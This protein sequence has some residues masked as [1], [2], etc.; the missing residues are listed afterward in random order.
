[1][2]AGIECVAGPAGEDG[3]ALDETIGKRIDGHCQELGLL[4]RPIVNMCV[5]SPPLTITRAQI[6]DM[7][8]ILREGIS[9]TMDDLEREGLWR[10]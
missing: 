3:G 10:R 7:A 9:R 6:D 1:M 4:V 2:M 5:M 8:A